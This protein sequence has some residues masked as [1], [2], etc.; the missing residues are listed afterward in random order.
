VLLSVGLIPE[1]ELTQA[2][3]IPIDPRTRGARVYENNQTE[4]PGIFAAGNVLHV[5][6]LVD[7]VTAESMR[8]G[9]AAARCATRG[10]E[11]SDPK[12]LDILA[13]DGV[14][15]TVPQRARPANVV[16]KLDVFFRARRVFGP[17]RIEVLADDAVIHSFRRDRVI[18]PEMERVPIPRGT[19]DQAQS[20]LTL[21][22]TEE[23]Q[24][25]R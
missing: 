20:T 17:A 10:G 2:A 6:D 15:Y 22:I 9:R 18:P 3:G 12:T 11:P 19:L 24:G 4:V 14:A 1:N 8:A 16:G 23:T 13:G 5:H 7:F 25:E 21:R